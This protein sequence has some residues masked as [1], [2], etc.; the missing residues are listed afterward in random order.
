MRVGAQVSSYLIAPLLVWLDRD[1]RIYNVLPVLYL[2]SL[3]IHR[4]AGN[5][6]VFHAFLFNFPIYLMGMWTAGNIERVLAF[7]GRFRVVLI[8][9]WISLVVLGTFVLAD[10]HSDGD[11]DA[12]EEAG[13]LVVRWTPW[14]YRCHCTDGRAFARDCDRNKDGTRRPQQDGYR[15]VAGDRAY[16]RHT[17]K[18]TCW[19]AARSVSVQFLSQWAR[20]GERL[21]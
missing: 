19:P 13:V 10:L 9:V 1:G 3:F 2:V 11:L 12:K 20:T 8:V 15:L 7:V 16:W 21:F 18:V 6:G 14:L 5:L 17:V 4:P